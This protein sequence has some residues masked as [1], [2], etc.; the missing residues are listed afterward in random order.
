M[1]Q[2]PNSTATPYCNQF[3]FFDFYEYTI[4]SDLFRPRLGVPPSLL[5]MCDINNPAGKRT[6]GFLMEGAGEIESYCTQSSRYQPSDLTA[7]TGASAVYL[8]KLNACRSM[9]AA[10]QRLKPGS[11]RPDDCPGAKESMEALKALRDGATI[12]GF[13]ETQAAGLVTVQPFNARALLPG[14][15][16]VVKRAARLFPNYG[17]NSGNNGFNQG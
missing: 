10:Y 9:W 15:A 16:T 7:L 4:L 1:P 2:I 3:Q 5:A 12:F 6:F 13:L 8:Q 11:A 14:Q 17:I